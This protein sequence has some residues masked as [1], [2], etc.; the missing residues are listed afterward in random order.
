MIKKTLHTAFYIVAGCYALIMLDL[1]FRIGIVSSGRVAA[2]SYNLI[3][4]HTIWAFLSGQNGASHARIIQ[5]VPGNIAVFI[6][7]GLYLQV[8]LKNKSFGKSVWIVAA[9]SVVAELIQFSFNLGT[10]DIDDVILNVVGGVLGILLYKL[11][12]RFFPE[13]DKAKTAAAVISLAVGI[14]VIAIYAGALFKRF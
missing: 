3:P 6:P 14:P 9:T 2:R 10:C 5:N 11:L 4:F 13:A 7:H 1:L 8:L 12:R